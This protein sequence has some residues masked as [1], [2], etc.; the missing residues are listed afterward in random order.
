MIK[1]LSLTLFSLLLLLGC[2]TAENPALRIAAL[3]NTSGFGGTGIIQRLNDEEG[4]GFGGTGI[5]GNIQ[6]FGSIWVNGIKVEYDENVQLEA[7][8]AIPNQ[9]LKLGQQIILETNPELTTDDLP[10]TQKISIFYPIA[11]RIDA[12]KPQQIQVQKQW[13]HYS[14]NTFTDK[15]LNLN[16]GDYVLINAT[17]IKDKQWLATRLNHNKQQ[18]SQ[19]QT[20]MSINFSPHIQHVIIDP[21]LARMQWQHQSALFMQHTNS[22]IIGQWNHQ[23]HELIGNSIQHRNLMQQPHTIQQKPNRTMPDMSTPRS[24]P[25]RNIRR[26]MH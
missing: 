8:I 22:I 21:K 12:L 5:V 2:S 10:K 13:I 15:D 11:G 17:L 16:V 6:G 9:R 14:E 20:T 25:P 18:I 7:N 23:R 26:T 1:Q 24:A 4:N 3:E 19:L